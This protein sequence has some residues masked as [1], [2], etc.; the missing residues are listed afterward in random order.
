MARVDIETCFNYCSR[1]AGFFSSNEQRWI[2]KIHKLK[3]K[4]PDLVTI[5]AE[6]EDNDG[7]I[8]AKMP[9]KFLRLQG[10]A[11][12]SEDIIQKSR[13]RFSKMHKNRKEG[14]G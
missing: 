10:P 13:D 1:E 11:S 2:N 3:D 14:L 5:L 4:H 9:V 6:P 12:V 8:Y 7:T